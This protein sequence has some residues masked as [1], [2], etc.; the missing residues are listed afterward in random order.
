M[1]PSSYVGSVTIESTETDP[2]YYLDANYLNGIHISNPYYLT[3][4]ANDA[5][6]ARFL[7][8]IKIMDVFSTQ[9]VLI[10]GVY[11]F[12]DISGFNNHVPPVNNICWLT[13]GIS[14]YDYI[15]SDSAIALG[16]D[17]FTIE[18]FIRRATHSDYRCIFDSRSSVRSDGIAIYTSSALTGNVPVIW[19]DNQVMMGVSEIPH[20]EW[21][22][23]AVC[24]K[25]ETL[26]Y[27]TG[28]ILQNSANFTNN[29]TNKSVQL[30]DS[31]DGV[32]SYGGH[33]DE[34]RI[35]KDVARYTANFIPP[36][37]PFLNY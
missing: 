33:I 32:Q 13:N 4:T 15:P 10:D 22:H 37:A 8:W 24:R 31:L 27:F 5:V 35:T 23:I 12:T 1:N 36:D 26:Y 25:S 9:P 16:T 17:D 34:L 7:A 2:N 11:K 3:I 14:D 30:G 28:G 20:S 21:V 19:N 18:M 6:E 29:L